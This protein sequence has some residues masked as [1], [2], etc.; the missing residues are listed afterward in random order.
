MELSESE[1]R[2]I[3]QALSE[4]VENTETALPNEH[5]NAPQEMLDLL[6]KFDAKI[7]IPAMKKGKHENAIALEHYLNDRQRRHEI[8]GCDPTSPELKR[9]IEKELT[10]QTPNTLKG[11]IAKLIATND[12]Q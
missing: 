11:V 4:H 2:I 10:K 12:F 3:W 7:A 1:I 6:E 9:A 5:D 8:H